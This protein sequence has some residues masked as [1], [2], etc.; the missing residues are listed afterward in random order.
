MPLDRKTKIL[1]YDQ[2]KHLTNQVYLFQGL[3]QVLDSLFWALVSANELTITQELR[4]CFTYFFSK[5]E[6][7]EVIHYQFL[8]FCNFCK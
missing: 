3:A 2:L 8:F 1:K 7:E 6:K 5:V 4:L